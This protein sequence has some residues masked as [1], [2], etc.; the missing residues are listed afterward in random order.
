M[1]VAAAKSKSTLEIATSA[2]GSKDVLNQNAD[3]KP[4]TPKEAPLT[5]LSDDL[6]PGPVELP[7]E[8]IPGMYPLFLTTMTQDLFKVK[9]GEN[10]TAEKPMI[11]IPKS[12]ILSDLFTRAAISDW[13]PVKPIIQVTLLKLI[14]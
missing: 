8:P 9:V 11:M 6:L 5:T 3:V 10:V 13:F 2:K 1:D 7:A 4:A 14:L 12:D